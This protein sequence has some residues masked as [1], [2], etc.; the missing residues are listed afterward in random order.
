[1]NWISNEVREHNWYCMNLEYVRE[2]K[3]KKEYVHGIW[4]MEYGI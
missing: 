1:M 4:N 2:S 3:R